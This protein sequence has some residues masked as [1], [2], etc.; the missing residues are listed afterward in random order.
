MRC[1]GSHPTS[2]CCSSVATSRASAASASSSSI[3]RAQRTSTASGIASL[4]PEQT[5]GANIARHVSAQVVFEE[6]ENQPADER[7]FWTYKLEGMAIRN[8]NVVDIINDNDFG[9]VGDPSNPPP[10]NLWSIRLASQLPLGK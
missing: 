10:T 9:I 2:S 1:H 3:S 4:A 5:A 6:F 8:A 7:I